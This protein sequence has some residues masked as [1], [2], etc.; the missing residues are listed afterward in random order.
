MLG[1]FKRDARRTMQLRDDDAFRA[2]DDKRAL[3]RHQR[4]LAHE[5][6]FFFAA[7]AL[8]LEDEGHIQ[9]RAVG[10]AFAQAFEPVHLRLANL[11]GRV[12]ELDFFIVAADGENLAEN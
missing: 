8:F 11:V 6:F 10:R 4:Q 7:L 9:R 1:R 2:I 12:V 3:R 5:N